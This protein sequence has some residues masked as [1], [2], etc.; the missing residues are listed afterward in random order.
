[1]RM[2]RDVTV[3]L[4]A[5]LRQQLPPKVVEF[6]RASRWF[7]YLHIRARLVKIRPQVRAFGPHSQ[8]LANRIERVNVI[9]PTA[10]CR[11][12]SKYGSDKGAIPAEWHNYTTVYSMLFRGFRQQSLRIFEMGLGTNNPAF[13]FNMG[14][15]GKPGASLRAWRELFPKWRI[16]GADIDRSTL[17]Q[18]DRINTFHCDQLDAAA[19]R[20]LWSLSELRGGM[21]IIIDDGLHTFEGNTCFL[22]ASLGHLRDGG[23]YIIEDIS[24]DTIGRWNE[25]IETVY[26][27][28]YPSYQ[29]VFVALPCPA[30]TYNNNLLIIRRGMS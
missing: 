6:I 8:H 11:V 1:M 20:D 23:F 5:S 12:L 28:T 14:V 21:D 19:I 27:Q 24:Y 26:A 25:R 29:F 7:L 16:Y 22:E 30:N 17:F 4:R 15:N 2:F 10:M 3:S 18:E 13:Q 9:K